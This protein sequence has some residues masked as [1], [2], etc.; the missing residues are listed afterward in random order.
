M[1]FS[2]LHMSSLTFN[3]STSFRGC[4]KLPHDWNFRFLQEFLRVAF[5]S[6][7]RLLL[8]LLF[9]GGSHQNLYKSS[10]PPISNQ[11]AVKP[12]LLSNLK[13]MGT[14]LKG[15]YTSLRPI[16][17]NLPVVPP[18]DSM[19]DM[20][21]TFSMRQTAYRP[22]M[23]TTSSIN[24]FTRNKVS[25]VFVR[26][27]KKI[28]L[29]EVIVLWKYIQFIIFGDQYQSCN[30]LRSASFL[31][32]RLNIFS[33]FQQNCRIGRFIIEL[34]FIVY[35][36]LYV[37]FTANLRNTSYLLTHLQVPLPRSIIII[38]SQVNNVRRFSLFSAVT[39]SSEIPSIST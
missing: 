18:K 22:S 16:S 20:N 2:L 3:M 23:A 25:P 10:K 7:S 26:G 34:N 24:T 31:K 9:L 6:T 37:L 8:Q 4:H 36:S 28:S 29:I 27:Y 32:S 17:A 1:L 21:S 38:S 19:D 13:T 12:P 33:T 5:F 11:Q 35:N 15:S 39:S 14:K 30:C